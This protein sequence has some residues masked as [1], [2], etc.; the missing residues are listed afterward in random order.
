MAM[1]FAGVH[2]DRRR[3]AA[4]IEKFKKKENAIVD[5]DKENLEHNVIKLEMPSWNI[6]VENDHLNN[7]TLAK[8][9]KRKRT[10]PYDAGE[11]VNL[12]KPLQVYASVDESET[13]ED[14]TLQHRQKLLRELEMGNIIRKKHRIHVQGHDV[15]MPL[16]GFE[17]LRS[18]YGCKSY[19]MRNIAEAGY[20]DPTPIQCQA[21]PVLLSGRECFACAPT[22]S[23]KTLAFIVPILTRLK[24]PSKEG[25]R[26]LILSPTRELAKQIT[27]EFKKF[28]KGRK[29]RIRLMTKALSRCADFT[30]LPCDVLVSTPLRLDFLLNQ[31]KI[32]LSRVENLVLDESDKLFELGFIEQIDAVVN[33]CTNPSIVR[34]LFSATLPDS[35][36]ELA[37]SIM[38]DA[39]RIIVGEKNT[40]SQMINQRLMFV[41]SEEGKLLALRQIFKESLQPPI[42]LFV[43]SKDRAKELHRELAFDNMNIDSIH[44]DLTQAQRERAVE[45]FREGKTWVLI[46]TDLMARGMDFKGVNCII[47]FDFPSTIASYIHRIGRS[48]RGGRRGQAVTLYTEDDIPFLRSIVNVMVGSG[49]DVPPWMLSLQ[50]SEKKKHI[51]Q[52]QSLST[53]PH[54][55]KRKL[56]QKV[57]TKDLG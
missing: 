28:S 46:A 35:V 50:K 53:H 33:A 6:S 57:M 52:R 13:Q 14:L 54:V 9:R 40:A 44:A 16:Q 51:P 42:L 48:G 41:G 7:G 49:C 31:S 1:L 55:Q 43:Q 36:E 20:R 18:T 30:S 47:N 29:F 21:I 15:P 38:H 39:V 26:A 37:C 23:G 25:I 24:V 5:T 45:K 10:A 8:K 12:F 17:E 19:L 32:N 3:F 27:Q 11:H 22:G 2:F 56:H 4:D 34:S